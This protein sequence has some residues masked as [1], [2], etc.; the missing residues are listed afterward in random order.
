MKDGGYIMPANCVRLHKKEIDNDGELWLLPGSLDLAKLEPQITFAHNV[1]NPMVFPLFDDII[2]GFRHL[3]ISTCAHYK[4]DFCLIDMGPSI[5]E[6]N[7]SLF[8]AADYFTIPCSPDSYCKTTIKT[9]ERTLPLWSEKQKQLARITADMTMPLNP[10]C[11]KFLGIMMSLFQTT[12]KNKVPVK[13]TQHWMD[14]V[15]QGVKNELVPALAKCDMIHK[16]CSKDFTLAE[17]PH[18]LSLMPI[19][20]R[21]YCPVYDIPEEGFCNEDEEGDLKVMAKAEIARHQERAETFFEIYDKLSEQLLVM[22]NAEDS[23]EASQ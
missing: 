18:F 8:W 12:G 7:K 2:G 4:I 10:E 13:D 9:M 21:S 1:T 15:K 11:P 6:L 16:H 17:I 23:C 3:F 19:A 22:F 5:G 14:I 20:Q